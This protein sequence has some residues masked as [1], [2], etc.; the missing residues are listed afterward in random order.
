[1]IELKEPL[2]SVIVPVYN[3]EAYIDACLNSI[4]KQTYNNLEIIIIEDCSTDRSR[5]VLETH[6]TDKRIRLI[7]HGKNKGLSAARNTGIE[8][9]TGDYIVFVDS[10]DIVD[11]RLVSAC[12]DC[13]LENDAEVVTYGFV[14]FKDGIPEAELPYSSKGLEFKPIIEDNSYFNLSHF[15]CLKLIRTSL[16]RSA[17]LRFAV[18]LHY[19]DWPF[20]WHLGLS[21]KHI[22]QLPANFY[23]YRQRGSSITGSTGK[24]LLDLFVVH[25]KVDNILKDNEDKEIKKIFINKVRQSH[26]VILT[27]IDSEHLMTALEKAREAEEAFLS[28]QHKFVGDFRSIVISKIIK[29]PNCSALYSLKLLRKVLKKR[30]QFKKIS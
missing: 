30:E 10:D 18:G 7:Q 19:E 15:A 16:I 2:V 23:L 5:Q 28:Q 11:T 20:H 27:R 14:P 13:A 21:T 3:V 25:S 12:I 1:M 26:W 17:S 8:Y 24:E 9:A 6:L 29:M 4:M 22:Y